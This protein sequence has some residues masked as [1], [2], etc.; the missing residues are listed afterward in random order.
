M[1]KVLCLIG[2]AIA[3]LMLLIFGLDLAFGFPFGRVDS[4]LDIGF[5]VSAI[6]LGYGSWSTMR[7]LR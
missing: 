2:G 5:A 4:T 6:I 7:A 3:A 1:S